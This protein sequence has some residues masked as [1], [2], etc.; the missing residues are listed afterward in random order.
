MPQS[1]HDCETQGDFVGTA[2]DQNF[3]AAYDDGTSGYAVI[4]DKYHNRSVLVPP[5]IKRKLRTLLIRIL[6]GFGMTGV[7]V[8]FLY[9][10]PT[11]LQS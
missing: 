2:V 9:L 11:L 10:L 3:P 6:V 8:A 1:V 4:F 5:K 7:V